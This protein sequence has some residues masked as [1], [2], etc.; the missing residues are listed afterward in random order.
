VPPRLTELSDE[1]A[2]LRINRRVLRNTSPFN[3][4]DVPAVT[5]PCHEPG[6]LPVGL[7]L[8]GRHLQDGT[9][10]AIAHRAEFALAR[11]VRGNAPIRGDTLFT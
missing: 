7:M 10:L 6:T 11:R 1:D 5:M 3:I 9:L 8:V 2:T 4:L